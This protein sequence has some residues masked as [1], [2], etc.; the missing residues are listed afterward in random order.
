MDVDRLARQG[1]PHQD[2]CPFCDQVEES[3]NHILLTCVFAR[4]VWAEI[5]HALGKPEWVPSEHDSL[6]SWLCHKSGANKADT[7]DLRTILGLTLWELWKHRNAIVFDG[8]RPSCGV[9]LGR[10]RL[11]GQVWMSAGLLKG[12]VTPFLS[13][14]AR[15]ARREE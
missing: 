4:V 12:D 15:W 3:I 14:L 10:N 7:K 9:L 1:L 5:C 11:E 6:T 2:A 13:R 8:A